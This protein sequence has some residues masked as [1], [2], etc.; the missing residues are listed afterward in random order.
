M[1]FTIAKDCDKKNAT[2]TVQEHKEPQLSFK[3]LSKRVNSI[4]ISFNN[5][6]FTFD[7][8]RLSNPGTLENNLN[9]ACIIQ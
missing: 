5:S 9:Q 7:F 8:L 3:N 1:L 2:A 6:N 4:S